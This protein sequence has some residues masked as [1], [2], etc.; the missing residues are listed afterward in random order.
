MKIS[1][2]RMHSS[3][4]NWIM[5]SQ[6]FLPFFKKV[7]ICFLTT[8]NPKPM[9][10]KRHIRLPRNF[11]INWLIKATRT[12]CFLINNLVFFISNNLRFVFFQAKGLRQFLQPSSYGPTCFFGITGY[13][14]EWILLGIRLIFNFLTLFKNFIEDTKF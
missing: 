11:P 13:D 6:P 14:L 8:T 7:D 1:R 3:R 12:G 4:A 9:W 2:A 5:L 10:W